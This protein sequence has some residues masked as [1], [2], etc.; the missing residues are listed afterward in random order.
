MINLTWK[1]ICLFSFICIACFTFWY[2]WQHPLNA[3]VTIGTTII[4]VEMAVTNK[5]KETGL[6][7]RSTLKKG[8]GMLFVYDHKEFYLFTM[9]GMNFPLD[10]IWLD[11]N[12]IV[13]LTPNVPL[14][15]DG[16]TTLIKPKREVDKI[17]ELNA[18]D[19]AN[20]HVKIGDRIIFNK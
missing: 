15:T 6:S 16:Q 18:G 19:I 20:L 5:E 14:T 13:D 2:Y 10:F 8:T 9:R 7:F 11:G 3:S 12:E 4:P 1:P 17:L